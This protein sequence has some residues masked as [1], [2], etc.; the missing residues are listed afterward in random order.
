MHELH[1]TADVV[2]IFPL[3]RFRATKPAHVQWILEAAPWINAVLLFFLFF[4]VNSGFVLQPGISVDLPSAPMVGGASYGSPVVTVSQEGLIFFNDERTTM[5]G[6][7]TLFTA[8]PEDQK[9]ASLVI[10][11]DGKVSHERLVQIYTMALKA[12]VKRVV[13][14][15]R[16]APYP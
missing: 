5:D 1:Q 11:A 12:G 4:I 10:E 14:A 3:R 16:I 13:L 8:M 9:S 7:S 15:T 2:K 6:L